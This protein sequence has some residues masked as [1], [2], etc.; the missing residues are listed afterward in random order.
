MQDVNHCISKALV[1][2]NPL[3]TLFVLEDLKN[4]RSSLSKT[5]N[6]HRHTALSWAYFDLE[7]KL[8][9]KALRNHQVIERVSPAYSSQTCPKCGHTSRGNRKNRTH[10]FCCKNC[11]YSSNDDRVAAMNLHRRGIELLFLSAVAT[12]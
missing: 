11:G 1:T 2:N 8:I 5:Q 3:G 6:K 9:Y 7:R 10:H 12:E 4:I